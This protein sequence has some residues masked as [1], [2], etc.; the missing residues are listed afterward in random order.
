MVQYG[1]LALFGSGETARQGRQVHEEL[2]GT[3]PVPVSVAI[4]ETPAGFQPNVDYVSRKLQE[5]VEHSL[6]NHKPRVTIIHAHRKGG[7]GDPDDP[8]VYAPLEEAGYILAGP[9][10]PTY[11]VRQLAGTRTLELIKERWRAGA[12]IALASAAAIALGSYVIPVYEIY[13]VGD[14]PEWRPG[15]G[16]L[17]EVGLELAIV[18]HWN[19]AEGGA[20]LDTSRCFIGEQRFDQLLGQLPS[21]ATVLGLDEHTSCIFDAN[22]RSCQVRGQ[23]EVTVISHGGSRRFKAR[24]GFSFSDLAAS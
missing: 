19:N 2:L 24:E 22:S 16:F 8:A 12:G 10:S 1:P 18:T 5:F 11:T 17:E 6:Q 21:G 15:L 3:L 9:G 7:P 23:G 13:K 4:L 14:D 20:N